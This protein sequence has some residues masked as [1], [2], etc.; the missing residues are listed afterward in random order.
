MR[1]LD[2]SRQF[3]SLIR[4]SHTV[5]ALPFAA[6]ACVWAL[7][8]PEQPQ[9]AAF[10]AVAWRLLG[11][12]VC[13]VAAR[14]AAMAFNRLVDASIDGANPRTAM[15]HLP[16]GLLSRSQVVLFFLGC[17]LIFVGG[18]LLFLPNRLP[19][20]FSLPVLAWICGYSFAKRFTAAAHL[21]LG[22]ALALSPLCAWVAIRGE[23]VQLG[24]SD[25]VAPA[26]LGAAIACW[27]AGFDIIYATQDADFDRRSGLHSIPAR[28]GIPRALRLAAV[29]HLL[30]WLLLV[31]IPWLVPQLNLGT[32]YWSSLVIVAVLLVRQHWIVSADDLNRVN[33]A[34]FTL[35]ALISFGLSMF[36]ALDACL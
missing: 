23:I 16:A 34:F 30:M 8:M 2:V 14:S 9:W 12:L 29:L 32:I 17:S 31:S 5:F 35:N 19:L 27:V 10:S 24:L 7:A 18:T 11:V 22:V 28:L 26:L 4:F 33:E 13:M 21:W 36:A 25:L 3:L 6:L 20:L 1:W 15:R